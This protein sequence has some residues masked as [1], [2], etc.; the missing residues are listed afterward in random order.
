MIKP[1]PYPIGIFKD[2]PPE[3]WY[4]IVASQKTHFAK[5]HKTLETEQWVH[6]SDFLKGQKTKGT[7]AISSAST[8]PTTAPLQQAA[9][10][11]SLC[12][13]PE[14]SSVS[15]FQIF[16]LLPPLLRN[17]C[18]KS[19]S[20][21]FFFPLQYRLNHYYLMIELNHVNLI[22]TLNH[23]NYCWNEGYSKEWGG[24]VGDRG[25]GSAWVGFVLFL[26]HPKEFS[27]GGSCVNSRR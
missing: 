4:T 15:I 18:P 1:A 5:G 11:P 8:L 14:Q 2:F 9:S 17:R 13:N 12:F 7:R 22:T 25:V 21:F 23:Y 16:F 6:N 20:I 19:L 26:E 27:E 3:T 10:L 24:G